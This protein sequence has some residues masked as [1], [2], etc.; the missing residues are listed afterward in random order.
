MLCKLSLSNIKKSIKDYAIYFVTLVLGV[1]IFYIFNS[2]DS[3]TAMLSVEVSKSEMIGLLTEL[4]SYVSVFVSFILGFL[5]IYASRFLIK[6]RNKE[7]GIYMTLGMSKG[8]ISRLL[9]IETF[10]IGVISLA[11]GLFLGVIL[12]QV[13]SIFV[14]NM[15]EASM[16]KFVFNFSM[17]ALV[18]TIIYFGVIYFIVMIN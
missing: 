17:K 8:K 12:S 14:A 9:L 5:I 18:K 7:F 11:V 6:K 15:F 2:V 10:L 4:L 13:T 3:Q 1:C 16:D